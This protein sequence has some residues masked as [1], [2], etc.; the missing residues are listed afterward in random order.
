MNALFLTT[1]ALQAQYWPT[2]A[3]LLE[4]VLAAC[5]GEFTVEDLHDLVT[6]GRAFAGV[7]LQGETPVMAMVFEFRHYPRKTVL[8]VIALGGAGL[9]EL[10]STF[11]PRFL[12]WAQESGATEIEACVSPA[13]ARMLKPLGLEH[14]YTVVR[15][16]TG[17]TP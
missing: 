6:D 16:P 9:D 11:W 14:V 15:M 3:A 2:A 13:M 1:P 10:A 8:N 17:A 5:R 7:A 12:E 4:P